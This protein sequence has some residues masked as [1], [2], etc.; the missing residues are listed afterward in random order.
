[1]RAVPNLVIVSKA[2]HLMITKEEVTNNMRVKLLTKSEIAEKL[3]EDLIKRRARL[4]MRALKESIEW[5]R[6][7]SAVNQSQGLV[8]LMEIS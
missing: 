3:W 5:A 8:A 2:N 6:R 7:T 4:S 1:M